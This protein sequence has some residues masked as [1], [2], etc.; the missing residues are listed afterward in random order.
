MQYIYEE[1]FYACEEASYT[2]PTMSFPKFDLNLETKGYLS[3][4]DS[5]KIIMLYRS[6]NFNVPRVVKYVY[7]CDK[8]VLYSE[9]ECTIPTLK[10]LD[11]Y[12]ELSKNCVLVDRDCRICSILVL[13][14]YS[15]EEN[16]IFY[17][18]AA[19]IFESGGG[20]KKHG[21]VKRE[22]KKRGEI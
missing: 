18:H 15:V 6:L 12:E 20:K 4:K 7:I 3:K 11:S 8:V 5:E 19:N 17:Q 16:L 13:N 9:T 1:A 21:G 2:F 22:K 14:F 10:D